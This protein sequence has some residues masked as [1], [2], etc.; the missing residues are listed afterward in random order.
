MLNMQ[1]MFRKSENVAVT[2]GVALFFVFHF[3]MLFLFEL[4]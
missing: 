4:V 2:Y 1:K 3:G